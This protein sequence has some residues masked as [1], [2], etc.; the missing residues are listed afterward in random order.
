MNDM[1]QALTL[2]QE[3]FVA[4]FFRHG[5]ATQA[6]RDA[7]YTG[8]DAYLAVQG[9]RLIRNDKVKAALASLMEGAGIVPTEVTR[10]L[11]RMVH[12]QPVGE[13]TYDH[14]LKAVALAMKANGMLRTD[15]RPMNV[16]GTMQ[17]LQLNQHIDQEKTAGR[18]KEPE[19]PPKEYGTVE[20]V[21]EQTGRRYL[22][23]VEI[24]EEEKAAADEQLLPSS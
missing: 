8:T 22:E 11:A 23:V 7:G 24:G 17:L 18:W 9:S 3:K 10:Q 20:K 1:Q 12:A 5:N 21:D 4:A 13:F 19:G 14:K 6:A 16:I 15:N 2:R